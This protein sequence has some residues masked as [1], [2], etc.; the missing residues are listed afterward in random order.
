[1][2]GQEP[3]THVENM[4]TTKASPRPREVNGNNEETSEGDED[5]ESEWSDWNA[6]VDTAAKRVSSQDREHGQSTYETSS[7]EEEDD[8]NN[9]SKEEAEDQT[10]R[11]GHNARQMSGSS[12]EFGPIRSTVSTPLR[13][14]DHDV[15]A[16]NENGQP[17]S[18]ALRGRRGDFKAVASND[19]A[20][21]NNSREDGSPAE[22]L[23]NEPVQPRTKQEIQRTSTK[24]HLRN[25]RHS[26][27]PDLRDAG[28][29]GD[30]IAP[31][32]MITSDQ[33]TSSSSSIFDLVQDSALVD[34]GHIQSADL[35][36]KRRSADERV[37]SHQG[38][39]T[40]KRRKR[41]I[42]SPP[43]SVPP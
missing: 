5:D 12:R 24:Q 33:D 36:R 40:R 29:H 15:Q 8:A 20:A 22:D 30:G 1:M 17:H 3:S 42:F 32:R 4:G 14:E 6:K 31:V 28:Q 41:S 25:E 23:Q 34:E 39:P 10:S 27:P 19:D 2:M 26:E 43:T 16:R 18:P 13:S 38:Q 35:K 11:A 21:S 37:S 7:G 9:E